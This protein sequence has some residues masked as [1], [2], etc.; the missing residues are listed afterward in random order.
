MLVFKKTILKT[1]FL[2]CLLLFLSISMFMVSGEDVED[3]IWVDDD[4]FY[5]E[6]SDGSISKPYTTIQSAINAAE[7]ND[8]IKV[9]SGEYTGDLV[10]DKSLT[11]RADDVEKTIVSSNSKNAFMVDIKANDVSIE[12]FTF[13]DTTNTSHRKA[14]VHISSSTEDVVISNNVIPSSINSRGIF[15]DGT[16]SAVVKNNEINSTWGINIEM[17]TGNTI[18]GNNITNCT[19]YPGVRLVDA[20]GNYIENNNITSCENGVYLHYS[21]SNVIKSNRIFENTASGIKAVGGYNN[22]I[23][24]N[25]IYENAIFGIQMDSDENRIFKNLIEAN[26]VGI[27]LASSGCIIKNNEIKDSVS[28]GLYAT[29]SSSQNVI[30]R[31]NF[32][33]EINADYAHEEGDNQWDNGAAG[34]FWY[35]Y[36]GPDNNLDGIG[37]DTYKKGGVNDRYPVGRFQK[38]PLVSNPRPENLEEGV[39]LK[40]TL[41]VDVEDPEGKRMDV[42]FYYILDNVSHLIDVAENVESGSTASIPFYSTIAGQN[43]VYSY[44]GTGYD[45]ICVWYAVAKDEH[46]ENKSEEWIFSTKNVPIDNDPP[47]AEINTLSQGEVGEEINFDSVGSNDS[48]GEIV[49]YRWSFGDDTSM[50]G[51]N[52]PTHIYEK[53]GRYNV[54]LV[55]IDNDGSSGIAKKKVDIEPEKNEAPVA[56]V[57]GPYYCKVGNFITFTSSGSYDPDKNEKLNYSWSFGDGTSSSEKN[58]SHKYTKKGNYTLQLILTDEEGLQTVETSYVVV[59]K[60]KEESPGFATIVFFISICVFIVLK[61]KK[62]FMN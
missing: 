33:G 31:N 28:Y 6:E 30:Y 21:E 36:L 22:T 50:V 16:K 38:P 15:L 58:P 57:N 20:D 60:P 48:D 3:N 10:I 7:D 53:P 25:E 46:S 5:P 62:V 43:A 45:Y 42:Y 59:S 4:Y 12:G 40:P 56:Y 54:S 11:L 23:K 26:N 49:F 8:T 19:D 35:D 52:S 14:V 13:L 51:V 34:N 37:E 9:L 17:S 18:V 32:T 55:V 41:K 47:V 2:T 44:I 29:S 24:D 39:D 61:K 27:N 1:L